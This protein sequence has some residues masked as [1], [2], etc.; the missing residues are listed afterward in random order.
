MGQSADN[1]LKAIGTFS[2]PNT[3][4]LSDDQF[5]SLILAQVMQ[6]TGGAANLIGDNGES[7]GLLQ[8]KLQNGEAPAAC[9]PSGCTYDNILKML[10]QGIN[11]HSGT[12][13]PQAPG[14]AYWLGQTQGVGPAVRSYN[15]GSVPDASDLSVATPYSTESYVSDIGNRLTGISPTQFPSKQWLQDSCGFKIAGT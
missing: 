1:I 4:E 10:Q 11:G 13:T 12:G 8:V 3:G 6:E 7:H 5:H 2:S 14:I 15:S 9:D